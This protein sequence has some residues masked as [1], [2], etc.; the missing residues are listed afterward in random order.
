LRL[1]IQSPEP[2][3]GSVNPACAVLVFLAAGTGLVANPGPTVLAKGL[4]SYQAPPGWMVRDPVGIS[5]YQIAVAPA[6]AGIP[7]NINIEVDQEAGP[8]D[9]Y[10]A[11]SLA[12][13]KKLPQVED[14]TVVSQKTFTTAAGLDGRRVVVTDTVPQLNN[15]RIEQVF[16]YFDGGGDNKLVIT[17]TCRASD[18][19]TDEPLFDAAMKS[20]TLE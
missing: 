10:I 7:A 14:L 8:M 18:A 5:K 2:S 12:T 9:G 19:A 3:K 16:Y 11:N 4:L 17:A 13:L 6:P 1:S 15:V 20:M